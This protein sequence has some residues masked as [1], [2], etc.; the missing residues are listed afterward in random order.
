MFTLRLLSNLSIPEEEI[1]ISS[2]SGCGLF[3]AITFN[4]TELVSQQLLRVQMT[5]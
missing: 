3:V 5:C 4:L 1:V 2:I